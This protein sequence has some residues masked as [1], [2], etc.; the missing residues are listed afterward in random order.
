MK[1][2]KIL[3]SKK[4]YVLLIVEANS[5]KEAISKARNDDFVES[6]YDPEKIPKSDFVIE[7]VDE[8]KKRKND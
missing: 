1:R 3:I 8:E 2:Y 6:S 7:K 4:E 5:K